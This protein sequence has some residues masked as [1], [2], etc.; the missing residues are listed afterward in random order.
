MAT[1]IDFQLI[2]LERDSLQPFDFSQLPFG[3]M[4]D[5]ANNQIMRVVLE[6]NG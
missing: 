3:M 1:K 2:P 6:E 5:W 4:N